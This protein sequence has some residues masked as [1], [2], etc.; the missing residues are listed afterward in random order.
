M[1]NSTKYLG[2]IKKMIECF[3]L[4]FFS[5][6]V[7]LLYYRSILCKYLKFFC[8]SFFFF[9]INLRKSRQN[10]NGSTMNSVSI[11]TCVNG[12][13]P[14]YFH[15]VRDRNSL[16]SINLL[17]A[18][19]IPC[20]TDGP[21]SCKRWLFNWW[22]ATHVFGLISARISRIYFQMYKIYKKY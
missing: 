9:R 21:S 17:I 4:F 5:K 11:S 10:W 19:T 18:N 22:M 15:T 8:A 6:A 2:Q 13:H 12:H 14:C 1:I 7:L 20:T 16:V 3:L